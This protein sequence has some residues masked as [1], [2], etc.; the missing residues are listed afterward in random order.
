MARRR[1]AGAG[2]SRPELAVLVAS[3]RSEVA[4]SVEGSGL[5]GDRALW[6]CPLRYFPPSLRE[7]FSDLIPTHPLFR[8]LLASELANE[9]IERMGAVWAHEAASETGRQPWEVAAAYWAARQVLGLGPQMASTREWTIWRA[10]QRWTLKPGCGR[11]SAPRS[12]GWPAGTCLRALCHPPAKSS[13]ET[14]R[15]PWPCRRNWLRRRR[16]LS[17][18]LAGLGAPPEL[19]GEVERLMALAAIGELAQVARASGREV[20]AAQA[21]HRIMGANLSSP[22]LSEALQHRAAPD[23]WERW[24]AHSLCDD[25]ARIVVVASVRALAA[26]PGAPAE[27]AGRQWLSDKS[28]ALARAS[29]LAREFGPGQ[30]AAFRWRP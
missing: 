7:A 25:L 6:P 10:Q 2:L 24:Q 30:V 13:R 29:K 26:Y 18:E 27:Q 17:A 3:A 9:V 21:L 4:H 16:A 1:E 19:A 20:S 11:S 12:T 23:R 14:G 8:Q 5:A 28:E 22:S 15:W